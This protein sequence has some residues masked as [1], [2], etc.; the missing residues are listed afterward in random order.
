VRKFITI[1]AGLL[2]VAAIGAMA[3]PDA[4]AQGSGAPA[5]DS[6]K[7][8]KDG[9][10]DMY[11]AVVADL[12]AKN[13]AKTLTDLDA[14][15]QKF[16][17]SDYKNDREVIY[18]T[19]YANSSQPAKAVDTAAGL[20][21]GDLDATFSAKGGA[22]QVITVLYTTVSC[23]RAVQNP[24]P[25]ETA[26]MSKAA[27]MLADYNRKPE[28]V[29]DADWATA[30]T[31]LQ[32]AAKGA[33]LYIAVLPGEQA[34]AK[35]D[36]PAAEAA[37][38]KA[39]KEIPDSAYIAY[40]LG[41][42][43]LCQQKEHPEKLPFAIYE[44]ERAAMLDPTL[45]GTNTSPDK[46]KSFADNAYNTLH[47]S[48]DG[49]DQLKEQAKQSPLPPDGFTIKT[50]T[51][52][53]QEKQAEFAKT[54]PELALWMNL[55]G[56]LADTNGEQYFEGTL[57]DSA[58]PQLRGTLVDAKPACRPKELMI[59]VP[60]PDA[61]GPPTA[62]ITLKLDAPLTGKPDLNTEIH[63]EGVPAAFTKDPFML[64]MNAE[65]AKLD[66]V[67]VSPC[68]TGPTRRTPRR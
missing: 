55:K 40:N 11:N 32:A 2:A 47:G 43:L 38:T 28:G 53:A 17:E 15:K 21:S 42:A 27:H 48:K 30:R 52:I 1:C 66:G 36:C 6:G 35:K 45:G 8:W 9:E 34:A 4:Q 7:N 22:Q 59:A 49:L 3:A 18:I 68:T 20:L 39:I 60:L 29:S 65:K 61:Q 46:V 41:R 19:A 57:K 56:Q 24:T 23:V 25:E 10:F 54:N 16:P 14:W 13:F 50:A 26:T 37:F 5:A 64:T 62:E 63:F 51:Q 67:K 12:G 44:Y 58:V 31:Q 33:L